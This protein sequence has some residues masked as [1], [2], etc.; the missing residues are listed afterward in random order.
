MV[1]PTVSERLNGDSG[2]L[3][4]DSGKHK[5]VFKRN[6]NRCSSVTRIGVQQLPEWVFKGCRNM[7]GYRLMDTQAVNNLVSSGKD[8]LI[9]DAMP[10]K[11]SYK[12]AHIPSAV[13]FEFPIDNM[14]EWNSRETGGKSLEAFTQLLGNNKN[15]TL[16]FYC[17][18]VKCGRSHN[19]A[20]WAVKLGYN[21]VYRYPGGI[22]AWKGAGLDT[23]SE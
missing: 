1:N 19:A 18:F 11:D 15:K 17:G 20:A 5:K 12:K 21:N 6:R 10:Y 7:H 14:P 8:A 22:Y 23:A 13:Q 9:I 2:H 4:A 3:N 16:V